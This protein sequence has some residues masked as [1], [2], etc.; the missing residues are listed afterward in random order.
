MR[1]GEVEERLREKSRAVL[2]LTEEMEGQLREAES[3]C[4]R[5]M[6]ERGAA[7][8]RVRAMEAEM[9]G[10]RREME[11]VEGWL[12]E[13]EGRSLMDVEDVDRATQAVDVLERQRIE[14]MAAD[15]AVDDVIYALDKAIKDGKIELDEY[16]K[17]I[18]KCSSEQYYAKALVNKINATLYHF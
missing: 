6:A 17:L 2:R 1:R 13:N 15:A 16:I 5:D 7:A 4:A 12:R 10:V 18:R 3:G 11:E 8:E 14:V 9:E